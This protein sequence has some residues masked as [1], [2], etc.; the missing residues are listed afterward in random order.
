MSLNHRKYLR[1]LVAATLWTIAIGIALIVG[2]PAVCQ[3]ANCPVAAVSGTQPAVA[4]LV[5]LFNR[6]GT[7][8]L[9]SESPSL[10][11]IYSGYPTA[12]LVSPYV[13]CLLLK[14]IGYT[15]STGW[16][17]FDAAY[18]SQGTTVISSDCG[19]GIMQITSGMSGGAGFD[20]DRVAA[21]ADYNIATGALVL[22]QK[23]NG[24]SVYIGNNNPHVVEDWYYAIWSYNGWGWGNNPNNG[25]F[26]AGRSEWKCGQDS[27]QSRK[28][29]PY[30]EL[31]WGCTSN[32][33]GAQFWTSIPLSLPDKADLYPSV[34]THI[35]TPLP[36]HGS[37]S[38]IYL[39]FV[40]Y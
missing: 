36:A 16:K 5:D 23:W 39:P 13:P 27:S 33:P 12:K 25:L 40:G 24:L 34:P 37:C 4:D 38:V 10:P 1:I 19:Y 18:G 3:A 9:G 7:D 15:E 11:K 31:I 21:E 29:W 26:L 6:A 20:P 30:Q 8:R 14:A 32:S 2:F 17:Q 28:D 22:I 35:D